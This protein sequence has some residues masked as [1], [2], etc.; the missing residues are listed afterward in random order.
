MTQ[1]V[2]S[3][4]S[5]LPSF[6]IAGVIVLIGVIRVIKIFLNE[7]IIQHI[8]DDW[9][10]RLPY[11]IHNNRYRG[12]SRPSYVLICFMYYPIKAIF[13]LLLAFD[14]YA[15]KF[16]LWDFW[17]WLFTTNKKEWFI[18][19]INPNYDEDYDDEYDEDTAIEDD[20]P[21]SVDNI[22]ELPFCQL[23]TV[24]PDMCLL[25]DHVEMSPDEVAYIRVVDD[26]GYTPLYKRKVR[27]DKAGNRFIVFNSTNHYLDDNKTQPIIK[28]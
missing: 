18:N 6:I 16:I 13:L 4:S 1:L 12:L 9:T 15:I 8:K 3:D 14:V 28:H 26:E 21:V 17:K 10:Y 11:R 27:R 5:Y 24:G 2:M 22:E 25:V 20:S 7:G 19:L 23:F